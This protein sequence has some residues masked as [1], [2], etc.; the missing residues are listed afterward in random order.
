MDIDSRTNSNPPRSNIEVASVADFS[1]LREHW[2]TLP[3]IPKVLAGR[4]E[5]PSISFPGQETRILLRGEESAG[6]VAV[7]DNFAA[8]GFVGGEHYQPNEEE[9]W[10]IL[11]GALEMQVGNER[12]IIESGAF[13]FMPR[14]C[15]HAFRLL[16]DLHVIT[17]NA[18][19]GHDRAFEALDALFR[20]NEEVPEDGLA[21]TVGR[22]EMILYMDRTDRH[23]IDQSTNK[24]P[25]S[26]VKASS[27]AELRQA[28]SQMPLIPKLLLSRE[29]APDVSRA[30][31]D[32]RLLLSPE[33]SGGKYSILDLILAP[34]FEQ[35]AERRSDEDQWWYIL[36]GELDVTAGN[37]NATLGKG[38][39][40]FAPR[41]CTS[42]Y[43]NRGRAPVHMLSVHTPGR[44]AA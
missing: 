9:Y 36:D 14:N 22:H 7:F 42:A 16:K 30:G 32:A 23:P 29:E 25:A 28:W 40:V 27:D 35:A 10:F 21:K 33:E 11:D 41:G 44:I 4:N 17:V 43:V 26:G 2:S 5:A 39:F 12:K 31:L 13:A 1:A 37:R 34:G 20:N 24:R 38:G 6:S 19:A 18:P 15:T 8:A 3:M